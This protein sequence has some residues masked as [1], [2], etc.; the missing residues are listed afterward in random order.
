MNERM[1]EGMTFRD[2]LLAVEPLAPQ[3]REKLQQELRTMFIRQ[4]HLP[5]RIFFGVIAIFCLATA[6]LCGYLGATQTELPVV[7]RV[8]LGIG[9][10]FG[11]TGAVMLTRVLRRGALNLKID[12]RRIAAMVWVFTVL[13]MTCFLML[14]MSIEDRVGGVL[15]IVYGLTFLVG[16]GVFLLA[17]RIEQ[18]ELGVREKLLELE[19]RLAEMG[20]KRRSHM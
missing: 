12:N 5:G 16:A 19:L 3:L 8:G 14:G 20:E 10:L 15:M 2:Q 1:N 18:A 11:L 6:V 4:L 13:M 7:A 17:Y 9:A